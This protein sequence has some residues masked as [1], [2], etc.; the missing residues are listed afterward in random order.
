M[1]TIRDQIKAHAEGHYNDGG[2]DVIVECWDDSDIDECIEGC[3][4]FEEALKVIGDVVGV[5]A[6]R[7][8]DARN[9]W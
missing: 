4:T 5:Y 9:C 8:A 7:Q 2:W 3:E 1:K 6:D